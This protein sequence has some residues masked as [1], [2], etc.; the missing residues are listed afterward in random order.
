MLYNDDMNYERSEEIDTDKW[1]DTVGSDEPFNLTELTDDQV[2][3][4]HNQGRGG[5]T[6]IQRA[7]VIARREAQI[8]GVDSSIERRQPEIEELTTRIDEARERG[9]IELAA[10]LRARLEKVH[11]IVERREQ[12]SENL[13]NEK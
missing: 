7:E 9:D 10:Q 12:Q 6:V 3:A 1:H 11:G 4:M 13:S 2:M 8:Q 5:D